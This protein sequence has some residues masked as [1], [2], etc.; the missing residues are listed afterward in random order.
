MLTLTQAQKNKIKKNFF[1]Y[2]SDKGYDLNE[3]G[4]KF[5]S[6]LVE[7]EHVAMVS[8]KYK[9]KFMLMYLFDYEDG[10]YTISLL[11]LPTG[12]VEDYYTNDISNRL[13]L[14]NILDLFTDKCPVGDKFQIM[15]TI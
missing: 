10:T 12:C 7:D 1:L 8:Y 11:Y 6:M 13:T 5:D 3:T 14:D 2:A 15:D 9:N 4:I